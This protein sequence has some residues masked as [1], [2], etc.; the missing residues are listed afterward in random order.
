MAKN[1]KE[2]ALYWKLQKDPALLEFHGK[3]DLTGHNFSD[4]DNEN[5]VAMLSDNCTKLDRILGGDGWLVGGAYTLADISW[6]PSI[7]TLLGGGFD[8]EP[9]PQVQD[10][11]RRIS[12]QP[13]FAKAITAWRRGS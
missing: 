6:A 9:Y 12:E 8:F 7:T 3:H 13:A 4:Q 5:S 2:V 10:W 11:Y 1:E